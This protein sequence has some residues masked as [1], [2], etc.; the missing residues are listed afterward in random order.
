MLLGIHQN[1]ESPDDTTK[2]VS[3]AVIKYKKAFDT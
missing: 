1:N 3:E 2:N